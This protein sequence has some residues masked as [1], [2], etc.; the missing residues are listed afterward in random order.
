MTSPPIAVPLVT[1]DEARLHL[2]VDGGPESPPSVIDQIV[3]MKTLQASDIV[4][5]Y[6]KQ[7]D[8]NWNEFTAPPLIKAAVLLVLSVL[9]DQPDGDPL[10]PGV[11]AI[12]HRYRDPALA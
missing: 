11:K 3:T 10:T 2:R 8:H 9:Y 6:I 7:L 1:D 5:D 4:A 12:L